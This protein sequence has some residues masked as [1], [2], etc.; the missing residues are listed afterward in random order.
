MVGTNYKERMMGILQRVDTKPITQAVYNSGLHGIKT[1]HDSSTYIN[2]LLDGQAKFTVRKV[3]DE[4]DSVI[5]KTMSSSH[6]EIIAF[7]RVQ[8]CI[9]EMRRELE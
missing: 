4:L 5:T 9:A 8:R 7:D 1:D 3:L 6:D 2:A